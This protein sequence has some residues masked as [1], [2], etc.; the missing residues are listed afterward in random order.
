MVSLIYFCCFPHLL[1]L[2]PAEPGHAGS[3]AII[4]VQFDEVKGVEEHAR[5]LPA[6]SKPVEV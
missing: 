1:Y 6:M 4:T 5:V 2:F 3:S